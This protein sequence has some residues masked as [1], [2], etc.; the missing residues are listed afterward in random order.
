MRSERIADRRGLLPAGLDARAAP[1]RRCCSTMADSFAIFDDAGDIP[2]AGTETFGLFHHGTRFLDRCE[3]RINGYFP[4]LLSP[5]RPTT[6]Q[7]LVIYLTEHRSSGTTARWCW[8]ATRWRCNGARRSATGRCS[9]AWTLRSYVARPV[10]RHVVDRCSRPTSPTIFELRG[11]ERARRGTVEPAASDAIGASAST[12]TGL[13]GVSRGTRIVFTPAPPTVLDDALRASRSSLAPKGAT[14]LRATVACRL[15]TPSRV[16]ST[17]DAAV[18]ACA[19]AAS[20]SRAVSRA[21]HPTTKSSTT[22]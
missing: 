20:L 10:T 19:S 3:L 18:G 7:Q 9:S 16:P 21:R 15:A 2:L 17:S 14:T 13:D 1:R 4:L 12:T 6:G 5:R 22:G 11:V 8:N